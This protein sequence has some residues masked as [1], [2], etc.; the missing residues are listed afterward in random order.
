MDN[1]VTLITGAAGF[2]GY[3]LCRELLKNGEKIIGIDNL[4]SYYNIKLKRA[5]LNNLGI[6]DKQALPYNTRINSI[7]EKGFRFINLDIADRENL[8]LLFKAFK[9]KRVVNLAA[10][11]GVRYS[12]DSP[13]SYVDSNLVGFSNILECCRNFNT[14]KLIYATSSSVYGDDKDLPFREES[15]NIK[16]KSFYAVTKR[17]NELMARCYSDLYNLEA[18]GLRFFT[19][20]GP[21]G[22]PDMAPILFAK[23]ILNNQEITVF[24]NG[25][26]FRDF[27]YVD[28]I[29]SGIV[30]VLSTKE[31]LK[32][33][34]LNIGY[35]SPINLLDFISLLEKS[36]GKKAK[37]KFVAMQ[38]GDVYK[39]WADISKL[40]SLTK[41]K[42][43]IDLKT[44]I[45]KF[46]KW[47]LKYAHNN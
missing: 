18:I 13:F 22:R 30:A 24:N 40:K 34:L 6:S 25:N 28:D 2:I 8:P 3:H 11:A 4:N 21:W 19:V 10:Q 5:R 31:N 16:Q 47:Y 17:A 39:T 20:Y 7:K 12:I 29:I 43:R 14:Q 32:H 35:G 1:T 27:T 42:P 36:F 26:L 15:I 9:I 41:Y 38:P 37:K 45:N 23:A 33:T 46:V 44:G